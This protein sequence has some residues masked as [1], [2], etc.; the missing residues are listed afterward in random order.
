M[1]E[2]DEPLDD[3][4]DLWNDQPTPDV[5]HPDAALD[6][7]TK[8][9]LDWTRRAWN[10]VPT[11]AIPATPRAARRLRSRFT[12]WR[13]AAA[14]LIAISLGFALSTWWSQAPDTTDDGDAAS[15]PIERPPETTPAP[16]ITVRPDGIELQAG[17]IRLVMLDPQPQGPPQQTPPQQTPPHQERKE[18]R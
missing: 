8:A 5:P 4:R 6:A 3:L 11:P 12:P 1:V 16:V 7:E 10:A 9:V 14:A 17:N 13:A 2:R 15:L 18:N